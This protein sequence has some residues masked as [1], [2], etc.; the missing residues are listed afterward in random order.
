M[1]IFKVRDKVRC[2]DAGDRSQLKTG[3]CYIITEV[4]LGGNLYLRGL[5]NVWGQHPWRFE[6][7]KPNPR[8]K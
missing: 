7:V 4:V 3:S 6:R 5:K 2:I 1:N 8:K